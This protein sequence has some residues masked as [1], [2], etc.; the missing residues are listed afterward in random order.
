[1]NPF[2]YCNVV[3][4]VGSRARLLMLL[5]RVAVVA[6]TERAVL[7]VRRQLT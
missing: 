6:W 4:H 3:L 2:N 7:Q 5:L 1:M